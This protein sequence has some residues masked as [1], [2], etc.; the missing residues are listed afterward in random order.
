M[1][2]ELAQWH[3]QMSSA[4]FYRQPAEDIARA[5]ERTTALAAEIEAA[6]KRWDHLEAFVKS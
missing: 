4:T 3:G 6:Y 2:E 5:N 1:E